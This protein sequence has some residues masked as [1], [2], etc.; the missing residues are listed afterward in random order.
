MRWGDVRER[1]R[2][3]RLRTTWYEVIQKIERKGNFEL[4]TSFLNVEILI[5][6]GILKK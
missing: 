4:E 1:S 2:E 6:P 3:E 5:Q